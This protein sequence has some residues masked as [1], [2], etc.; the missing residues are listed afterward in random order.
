MRLAEKDYL[1]LIGKHKPNSPSRSHANRG[2]ALEQIIELVNQSYRRHHIALISKIP[3]A[4]LPIRGA[5]GAIISAKVE[6]KSIVD[7]T[8]R[9]RGRPIAFD[10]KE[11][12]EKRM[13]WD[14]IE[15]HQELYLDDWTGDGAIGFVLASFGEENTFVIPWAEWKFGLQEW[16]SGGRASFAANALNPAWRVN[17]YDYLRTL[18]KMPYWDS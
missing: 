12:H 5:N 14:R 10:A 7:F 15:P 3:T 13:R 6:Q 2:M 8:G 9:W 1:A 18:A 4:W 16:R 17:K 11:S